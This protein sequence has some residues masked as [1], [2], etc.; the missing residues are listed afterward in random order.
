MEK[1]SFKEK[2]LELQKRVQPIKKDSVNPHFRNRYASLDDIL[3]EIK[4]IL[5]E[6]RLILSQGVVDGAVRTVIADV[7]S[8][9]ACQSAMELPQN[10]DP[11]KMGSAVTYYRRYTLKSLLALED[12][13]DDGNG[14][15]E[16]QQNAPQSTKVPDVMSD[17]FVAKLASNTPFQG[18]NQCGG[19]M[20]AKP[21]AKSGKHYCA[22]LCFKDENKHLQDEWRAE[23][24]MDKM[25]DQAMKYGE[26]KEEFPF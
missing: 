1:L 26:P 14:A 9:G 11:Q 6:M 22:R 2:L 18:C 12:T 15:T 20:S 4:P 19:P 8:D 5:S 21:S 3:A 25:E 24:H 17:D 13:D 10:L 7:D 23:K 16:G